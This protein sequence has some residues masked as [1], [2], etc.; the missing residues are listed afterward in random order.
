MA[1]RN[2]L[3][4][5]DPLLKRV[6]TRITVFDEALDRLVRDLEETMGACP[7]S[8]GV[9]APQIGEGVRVVVLDLSSKPNV[10]HHGPMRLVNPEILSREGTV[11]GREGCLSVPHYTGNVSRAAS[12]HLRAQ[13]ERGEW[14]EW[15]CE[16]FEARAVQHELDHL[17][18]LLFLDRIVSPRHDLFRRKVYQ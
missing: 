8:I 14:C 5:P 10:Q 12:V 7:G 15:V 3:L 1:V 17:D 13:N 4:Y 2:I 9:A 18:G 6:C 11:R 16:G